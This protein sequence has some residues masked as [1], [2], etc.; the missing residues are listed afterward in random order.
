MTKLDE[1]LKSMIA[2]WNKLDHQLRASKLQNRLDREEFERLLQVTNQRKVAVQK[3]EDDE[4]FSHRYAHKYSNPRD[5]DKFGTSRHFAN[6][7]ELPGHDHAT[8]MM[9]KVKHHMSEIFP[10]P[11]EKEEEVRWRNETL[12]TRDDENVT[13]T[14]SMFKSIM[15]NLLKNRKS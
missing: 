4:S 5:E 2:V 3:E 9:S 11:H 12:E 7:T 10:H 15:T 13:M 1:D 14:R 6:S 8:T